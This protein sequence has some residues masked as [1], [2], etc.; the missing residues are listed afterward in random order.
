MLVYTCL[1]RVNKLVHIISFHLIDA[2]RN[3]KCRNLAMKRM[4]KFQLSMVSVTNLQEFKEGLIVEDA[5]AQRI[6]N[7]PD[8]RDLSISK[9]YVET[10]A[11]IVVAAVTVQVQCGIIVQRLPSEI[12]VRL[13]HLTTRLLNLPLSTYAFTAFLKAEKSTE[14]GSFVFFRYSNADVCNEMWSM[15][16]YR[17]ERKHKGGMLP[18][19]SYLG[20][21]RLDHLIA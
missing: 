6:C 18:I 5:H 15:C 17:L 7:R 2:Y 20:S 13:F 16:I 19:L 12:F 9:L 14:G 3:T 10:T 4:A 11:G 8:L 21:R 1:Y